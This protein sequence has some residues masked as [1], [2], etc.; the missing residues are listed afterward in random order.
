MWSTIHYSHCTITVLSYMNDPTYWQI[1]V[2]LEHTQ[3]QWRQR[4]FKVGGDVGPKEVG[5]GEGCS[6]PH[7]DHGL[8]TGQ[9]SWRGQIFLYCDLKWRILVNSEVL[10]LKF[11]LSWAPSVGFGSIVWQILDFWAKRWIKDTIKCCHWARTTNIGLLYPNVRNNIGGDI[12]IDVP[13]Q[14]KY[15]RGCVPGIPGGVD[16]SAQSHNNQFIISVSSDTALHYKT[17]KINYDENMPELY[18]QAIRW[19]QQ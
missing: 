2:Q 6:P 7:Q 1:H 10:N 12:P 13:P 8:P 9:E 15:W 11:S 5:C 19:H 3:S 18:Y 16:A 4:E 17:Y 14:P